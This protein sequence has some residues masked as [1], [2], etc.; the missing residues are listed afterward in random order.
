[1]TRLPKSISMIESKMSGIEERSIRF[2]ALESAKSFKTSWIDLGQALYAVWK[3][4]LFRQWGYMTFEAYTSKEIGI[5][6]Q[7]AIKLLKSYSFLEREE[8]A[9]IAKDG[10]PESLPS[11]LP[12]YEAVNALRL[13]KDRQKIDEDDYASL[14]RD[15]FELGKDERE[16]KKGLTSLMREREDADP[17]E[18][19]TM[20]KKARLRRLLGVLNSIKNDIEKEKLLPSALIKDIGSLIGK[21]ERENEAA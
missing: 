2:R 21:I 14:R 4:K 1:M 9:M 10:H 19:R 15:V 17:D 6:N 16:V 5:R 18:A 20:R 12:G 11:K 7:T 13:A 3:D 8:P